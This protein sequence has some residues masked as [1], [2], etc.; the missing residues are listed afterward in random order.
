VT[1]HE[2]LL[3]QIDTD[4]R[5]AQRM[6]TNARHRRRLLVDCDAKEQIIRHHLE[7]QETLHETPEG[8][9]A[10]T[11]TPYRMAMEWCTYRIAAMYDQRPG[12][13][14]HWGHM[15]VVNEPTEETS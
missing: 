12:W 9:T 15:P 13:A 1:P 10:E 7:W 2:W 6:H 3:E 5:F 8:W 14:E 4:R 11:C